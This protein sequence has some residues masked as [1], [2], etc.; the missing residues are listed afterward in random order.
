MKKKIDRLKAKNDVM[1]QALM[2]F[3]KNGS[4]ESLV[5]RTNVSEDE[6]YQ[7][8][9]FF[10]NLKSM[11]LLEKQALKMARGR[12]LD[13]GAG[14]GLHSLVLQKQGFDVTAIEISELS[15]EIMEHRGVQE[16]R[17]VNFF[18][19]ENEKFD[20]IYFLM[21]GIG[22]VEQ[23]KNFP[24]FFAKCRELLNP[25]GQIIFDSS[26]I[27]YLFEEEDGSYLIEMTDKYYGEVEFQVEY[28]N[29]KSTPFPW[30]FIDYDNFQHLASKYGFQPELIQNGKHFDYLAKATLTA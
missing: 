12:I 27:I 16:I 13:V 26:D 19:F 10:R 28:K 20:T 18:N 17:C 14:T 6:E 9:Y 4:E 23:M 25:N 22:L 8:S 30:I 5:V 21:N 3:Y 11:P 24:H 15:V 1:G 2:D 29:K 7:L